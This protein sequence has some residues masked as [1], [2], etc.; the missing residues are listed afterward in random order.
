MKP[1]TAL[2]LLLAAAAPAAPAAQST[3]E[4][5]VTGAGR[6]MILIPGLACPGAVW[7]TTIESLQ[8]RYTCHVLSLAGFGGT[9]A[10]AT[11]G[12]LLAAVREELAA[13]IRDEKLDRPILVGHSLGGFLALDLAARHPGLPGQLVVVDALPFVMGVMRPDATAADAKQVAEST[14][15]AFSGMDAA[16]YARMIRGGPNGSTMAASEADLERIIAWGLAS[17]PAT[18]ARAMT[19]MYTSDLRADLGHIQAP[20]LA[21][22]AWVG[23]APYSS[24]EIVGRIHRD[25]YAR[26]DGVRIEITDTARHFIM[27]DDLPWMLAQIGDFLV[28]P[29]SASH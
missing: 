14:A 26:L 7:D 27:M 5:R 25:Q 6:P 20:T 2:C 10:R 16:T 4:V 18:V 3:F 17:D 12:P 11:D 29:P 1:I 28:A 9:P 23:Y 22:A 8:D 24:R 13:Y 19:E 21:L 15:A